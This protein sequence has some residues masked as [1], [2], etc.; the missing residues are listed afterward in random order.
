MEHNL[1]KGSRVEY[2]GNLPEGWDRTGIVVALGD[3]TAIVEFGIPGRTEV[4]PIDGL[5]L[6]PMDAQHHESDYL[7]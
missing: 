6:D 7:Q 5:T 3:A 2:A 4:V 1:T